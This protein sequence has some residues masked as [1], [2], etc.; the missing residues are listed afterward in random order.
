MHA[1]AA[2][3]THRKGCSPCGSGQHCP[4]GVPLYQRF[5]D[6]QDAFLRSL[7]TRSR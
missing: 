6:L 4:D 7:R 5:V 3:R 1:S 2:W